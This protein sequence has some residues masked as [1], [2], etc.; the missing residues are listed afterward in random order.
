MAMI[1]GLWTCRTVL[2][3]L[4]K[5]TIAKPSQLSFIAS[6]D[7]RPQRHQ[8]LS[9]MVSDRGFSSTSVGF[10]RQARKEK[11]GDIFKDFAFGS[12]DI[13]PDEYFVE[14][15][16]ELLEEET[17]PPP[18]PKE[19]PKEK[20]KKTKSKKD[21]KGSEGADDTGK[22]NETAPVKKQR[23]PR[24][25]KEKPVDKETLAK[26]ERAQLIRQLK[27]QALETPKKLPTRVKTLLV[28][29]HKLNNF[30][31]AH[32]MY[33][34]LPP[35]ERQKLE[36]RVEE[37]KVLNQ[38]A[39]E[40]WVNS[41]TPLQ[42][43]QANIARRRLGKLLGKYRAYMIHDDRLVARPLDSW[44]LFLIEKSAMKKPEETIAHSSP[45]WS[46]EWNQLAPEE[47][48]KYQEFA[49]KESERY[50]RE[51]REAYGVDPP[52]VMVKIRK[53]R[54]EAASSAGTQGAA[55]THD[56]AEV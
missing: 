17:P 46:E 43:K 24:P 31:H 38:K 8:R 18:P 50:L 54:K 16:P 5:H 26:R 42:I 10:A 7:R 13:D 33:L 45:K 14:D 32:E 25:K 21:T 29:E 55:I 20:P 28:R 11:T 27:E 22:A 40:E 12:G 53:E 15:E 47:K 49:E 48:K 35:E 30:K 39:Y 41:F 2:N 36:A 6:V 51:Y 52:V 9:A 23:K 34:E 3:R 4:R 1:R 19:K 56:E 37:N 44:K